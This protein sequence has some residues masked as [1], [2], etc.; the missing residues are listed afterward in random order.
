MNLGILYLKF[1]VKAM[2]ARPS[3]GTM[4]DIVK[5]F[6]AWQQ[7]LD[8][9][10]NSVADAQPW[11]AF[12]AIDF[13]RKR[14][15]KNMTVFEYGSGGSTLFCSDLAAKVISIE[16][17]EGWYR[18]MKKVFEEKG[19]TN[20]DYQFIPANTG[21]INN[22]SSFKDPNAYLSGDEAYA[23][24]SFKD[25]VLSIEA[26]GPGSL[27]VVIVDGRARPSCVQ[28]AISKIR[29]GGFLVVDNTE[30]DYYLSD[31]KFPE[32]DWNK[33]IFNGP[34]PYNYHFSQ[35]TIFQRKR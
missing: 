5:Y 8:K 34:V 11:M 25:Y 29:K 22:S 27:D 6:P 3:V 4:K 30:R 17:H 9:N 19:I 32:A 33:W 7:H 1:S 20:V 10:R 21:I 18:Q 24:Y 2:L 31:F 23:G 14:I 13:L 26:F 28:H 35:T 16:H 15:T 12:G